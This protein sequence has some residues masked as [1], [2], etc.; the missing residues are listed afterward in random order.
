[1]IS[2]RFHIVSLTAVFLALA[3]G[4]VVGTTYVDRAVVDS[5]ETR[6]DRVSKNLDDRKAENDLLSDEVHDLRGY[7]GVSA[8]FAVTG[9]L[10]DVPVVLVAVRG[11]S[12]SAADQTVVL[13]RKAG[14]SVAGV[15]WL[16]KKWALTDAADHDA[17]ATAAGVSSQGSNTKVRSAALGA[18]VAALGPQLPG[19]D[20]TLAPALL[21]R[22][23]QAGFLSVDP[24][25]NGAPSLSSMAGRSPRLLLITGTDA[26]E[27]LAAVVAQLA[28]TGVAAR[29]PTV[30]ADAYV[31]HDDGPKRG[32]TMGKL[33]D[34][35]LRKQIAAVDDLELPEGQAA[36]LLALADP[37]ASRN[38]HYGYGSGSDG[39]LPAWSAP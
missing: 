39:V 24:Q 1:M 28:R 38:A 17:L 15:A 13:A 20:P 29:L 3:I 7:A 30:L 21:E 33:V 23:V 27:D 19:T 5:L 35:A 31:Q 34:D 25:G 36:A 6:V 4:V 11:T 26:A 16:E 18:L 2:F 8:P 37:E 14:A 9:R 12:S 22:V 10:H 32:A